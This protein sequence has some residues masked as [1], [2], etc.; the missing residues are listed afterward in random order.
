MYLKSFKCWSFT[1]VVVFFAVAG[2]IIKIIHFAW[3]THSYIYT[4]RDSIL[5]SNNSNGMEKD[6]EIVNLACRIKDTKPNDRYK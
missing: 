2:S 5:N 6:D 4:L 1:S 3:M